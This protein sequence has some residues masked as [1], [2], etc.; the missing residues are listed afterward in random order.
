MKITE[1]DKNLFKELKSKHNLKEGGL[2]S[3]IFKKVLKIIKER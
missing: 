1:Q 2:V 3:L